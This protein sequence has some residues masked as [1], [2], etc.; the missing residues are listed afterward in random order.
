MTALR[1]ADAAEGIA[2]EAGL[3]AAGRPAVLLWQAEAPALVV[4]AAWARRASFVEAGAECA[5]LGWPVLA[6]SSGGGGVPQGPAVLNLAI[7]L[8]AAGLT[9][10]AGYGLICGAFREALTRFE[11][12]SGTGPV[13]GAFCDG[14]WNVTVAGRKLVG[15]AQRWSAAEGRRTA[16]IHAAMLLDRPEPR[17]WEALGHV[18]R[19]AGLRVDPKPE[20]HLAVSEILPRTMR[21]G[22]LIGAVAR[23]AE[24]RLAAAL[25]ESSPAA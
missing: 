10:E 15:T 16:L 12:A 19:A 6:R 24:D 18:H 11:I 4:P 2:R 23:A 13:E 21:P 8:P 5:R 14:R 7:V 1:L 22:A 9:L 20:A 17:F 3:L 25:G